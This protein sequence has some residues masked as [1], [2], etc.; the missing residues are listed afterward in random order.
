MSTYQQVAAYFQEK[1]NNCKL[2]CDHIFLTFYLAVVQVGE[3]A[4][5]GS[6]GYCTA[7]CQPADTAGRAEG[8]GLVHSNTLASADGN[9]WTQTSSKQSS[10]TW[11]IIM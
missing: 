1:I 8:T 4:G 9:K 10:T 5:A 11:R 6:E 3:G 7:P 2:A